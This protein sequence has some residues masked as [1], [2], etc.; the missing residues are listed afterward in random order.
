M[1]LTWRI[2]V[3]PA[4]Y[5]KE[6]RASGGQGR[7]RTGSGDLLDMLAM[8]RAATMTIRLL[9]VF[10]SQVVHGLEASQVYGGLMLPLSDITEQLPRLGSAVVQPTLLMCEALARLFA[11]SPASRRGTLRDA[12]RHAHWP[13]VAA[14]IRKV[15]PLK[16]AHSQPHQ[17][18]CMSLA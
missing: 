7:Q 9:Q 18:V 10:G 16:S 15:C 8:Q 13:T 5:T 4:L 12:D 6:A 3:L 17:A 11:A 14:E 1:G 2:P